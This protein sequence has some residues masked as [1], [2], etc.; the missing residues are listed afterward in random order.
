MDLRETLALSG[1]GGGGRG[2]G[3]VFSKQGRVS[4]TL[5]R[6]TQLLA[7]VQ[8]LS[9]SLGVVGDVGNTCETA[10]Y[11]QLEHIQSRIEKFNIA[12]SAAATS[13]ATIEELFP[14]KDFFVN[15]PNLLFTGE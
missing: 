1:A 8:R 14:F 3:E 4:W 13:T 10:E 12:V 11:F 2:Q 5:A 7:E 15:A 6:R 9:A